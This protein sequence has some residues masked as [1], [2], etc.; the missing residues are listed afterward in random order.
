A[1][2]AT[3]QKNPAAVADV[4]EPLDDQ[5]SGAAARSQEAKQWVEHKSTGGISSPDRRRPRL[6]CGDRLE[7]R[8][9]PRSRYLPRD[10]HARARAPA[11]F[12]HHPCGQWVAMMIRL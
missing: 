10:G 11:Y 1:P 6:T 5:R 3:Y 12:Y 7:H 2:T 8:D 4:A 9:W